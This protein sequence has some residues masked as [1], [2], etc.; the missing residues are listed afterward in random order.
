MQNRAYAL[1]LCGGLLVAG[2][3]PILYDGSCGPEFR[4]TIVQGTLRSGAGTPMGHAQLTLTETRGDTLTRWFGLALMGTAYGD[5]GPL[6]GHVAEARLLANSAVVHEFAF[7]PGN[8][9]EIIWADPVTLAEAPFEALKARAIAGELV[10]EL[11]STLE[12]NARVLTP[13]VLQ[14]AGRWD[15]ANCS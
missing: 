7:R 1:L 6:S 5:P 11:E 14:L 15:R 12:G 10:L 13:L 8:Q 9:H 2:C 4:Q 3:I